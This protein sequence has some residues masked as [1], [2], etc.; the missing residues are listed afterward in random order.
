MI[1]EVQIGTIGARADIILIKIR[2]FLDAVV[3][4]HLQEKVDPLLKKGIF[5]YIINLEELE[6]ISTAG[7]GFFSGLAMELQKHHGKIIFT[8]VPVLVQHLFNTTGLIGIFPI[9]ESVKD[10][11]TAIESAA[12]SV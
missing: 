2:G 10:A 5:K 3:A 11:V 6:H 12:N 7:I 9:R 1:N 8:N 4:Y